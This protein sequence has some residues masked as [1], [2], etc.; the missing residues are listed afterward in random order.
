MRNLK[1][2]QLPVNTVIDVT[3]YGKFLKVDESTWE[4]VWSGCCSSTGRLSDDGRKSTDSEKYGLST[5]EK[6]DDIFTDFKVIA[7]DPEVTFDDTAL[8]GNW[9]ITTQTYTDGMGEHFCKG[10]N[11]ND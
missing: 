7:A 2:S 8:H 11:C 3:D 6:A 5:D 1:P 10:Y 4:E 9:V